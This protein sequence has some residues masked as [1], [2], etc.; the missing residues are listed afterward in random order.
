MERLV[1]VVFFAWLAVM[2]IGLVIAAMPLILFVL[3][4]VAMILFI[5]FLGRFVASLFW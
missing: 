4:F 1:V 2:A 3:G 5:A